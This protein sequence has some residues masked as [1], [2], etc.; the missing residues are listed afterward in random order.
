MKVIGESEEKVYDVA[1]VRR[2]CSIT[3]MSGEQNF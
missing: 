1:S 2:L 3:A